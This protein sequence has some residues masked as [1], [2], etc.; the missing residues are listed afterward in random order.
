LA[1]AHPGAL[2]CASSG[3]GSTGHLLCELFQQETQVDMEHIPYKGSAPALTD[4][5]GGRVDVQ[6]DSLPATIGQ[7]RAGSIRIVSVLSRRRLPIARD[8]S[9][10][11]ESGLSNLH[12]ETWGGLMVPAGTPPHVVSRLNE[13]LNSILMKPQLQTELIELGYA[14][15]LGPNTPEAFGTLLARETEQWDTLLEQRRLKPAQ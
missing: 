4:V 9:T 7:I 1:K 14:V 2:T 10:I 5:I 15:P 8:V 12:V 11:E 3:F 13:T 6:F